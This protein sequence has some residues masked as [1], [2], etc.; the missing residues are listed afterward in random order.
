MKSGSVL[1][2]NRKN[3]E[4][5]SRMEL[6]DDN[7]SSRH[8]NSARPIEIGD[9]SCSSFSS[10]SSLSFELNLQT[11]NASSA[12]S[13]P[14][15]PLVADG[16]GEYDPNRIPGSILCTNWSVA[17][18]ESLFSI[19]MGNSSFKDCQS[20]T[21]KFGEPIGFGFRKPPPVPVIE[22]PQP[23]PVNLPETA[24]KEGESASAHGSNAGGTGI[25][26]LLEE[27]TKDAMTEESD[28]S[29]RSDDCSSTYSLAL[30]A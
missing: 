21:T 20:L 30:P 24:I 27:I 16:D 1:K 4:N 15:P 13:P 18:T 7:G 23:S 29:H 22:T 25:E 26:A 17:S 3:T 10:F 5:S 19:Q 6:E 9:V 12:S 14:R 11:G 2:Y 28:S 8:S